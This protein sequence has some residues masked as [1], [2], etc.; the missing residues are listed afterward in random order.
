MHYRFYTTVV[1]NEAMMSAE[2]EIYFHFFFRRLSESS[3]KFLLT[4]R[5]FQLYTRVLWA[6]KIHQLAFLLFH[7]KPKLRLAGYRRTFDLIELDIIF[8][9]T[10]KLFIQF[11]S[12]LGAIFFFVFIV[13]KKRMDS[14]IEERISTFYMEKN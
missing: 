10:I 13:M 8:T 14:M 7:I 4:R 12:S 5:N 11:E 9:S 2:I 6:K 1:I 3:V